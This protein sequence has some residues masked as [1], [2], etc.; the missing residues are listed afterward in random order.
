MEAEDVIVIFQENFENEDLKLRSILCVPDNEAAVT[1]AGVELILR[2][3]AEVKQ[4]CGG[5]EDVEEAPRGRV[6]EHHEA[7]AVANHDLVK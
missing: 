6:P 5:L 1:V 7:S 4:Q 2:P 3:P